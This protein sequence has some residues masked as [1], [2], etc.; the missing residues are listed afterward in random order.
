[1]KVLHIEES[2]GIIY[3][4]ANTCLQSGGILIYPT[5]T[6]YALG[7]GI[8][9]RKAISK[10]Y[11]LKDMD[12]KK[13]LSILCNSIEQIS[14]YANFNN[15]TFKLMKQLLPGPYTFILRATKE[16][17]KTMVS[18]Q[19]TIGV[20]IPDSEFCLHLIDHLGTPIVTTSA[21]KTEDYTSDP[22]VIEQEFR[23]AD[24][25]IDRGVLASVPSTVIDFTGLE[26]V[27]IREG[28]G[29]IEHLLS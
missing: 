8:D 3:R 22:Q 10:L 20:R 15:E 9:H 26:P 4:E 2:H 5:D 25:L 14:R 27:L 11:R 6:V 23:Q 16:V 12:T 19:K 1:M 21:S 28:K 7:C 18:K 29:P 17:P 13:P 24:L